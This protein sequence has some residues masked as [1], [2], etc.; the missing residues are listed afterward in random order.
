M[1]DKGAK[2]ILS[3]FESIFSYLE[4]KGFKLQFKVFNDEASKLN[5]EFLSNNFC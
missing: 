4:H 3:A 1:A 2:T 5:K